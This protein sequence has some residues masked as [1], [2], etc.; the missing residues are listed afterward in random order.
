MKKD[1]S[2]HIV[3]VNKIWDK[4]P[5]NAFTDLIVFNGYF[6]CAFREAQHHMSYDGKLRIIYS[7][8]GKDWN[9][10]ALLNFDNKD[11]RDA[12]FSITSKNELMLNGGIRFE[13]PIN[14][15]YLQSVTWLCKDGK[16]WSG[17][18]T[19]EEDIGTWRWST[20]W[21]NDC[22]YSFA[23]TGR[24]KHGCLYSSKDGKIWEVL[25][26]DVYP[27]I[28]S[29][30]N[31]TSLVFLKNNDAYSLL[32]RDKLTATAMLGY[33]KPPYTNWEWSDLGVRIGGPKMIVLNNKSFLATVRLYGKDDARTSLCWIDISKSTLTE[34]LT[35]PS[36]AD[37]SYAGMVE[38]DG[39][40]WVSYYSSHEEKT[41]IYFAKI[42]YKK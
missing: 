20:T 18:F 32:R 19:S 14:G 1:N 12:K 38:K 42:E 22:A 25:K 6:Y 11:L 33:S 24:D 34:A 28:E 26:K 30:G 3:E 41:A 40:I 5:H 2:L 37:S 21:N 16:N 31:E 35:L 13:K 10:L 7:K 29:Y 27:D 39:F 15:Y 23:Y 4:A 36:E 9:S 8:N 17:P